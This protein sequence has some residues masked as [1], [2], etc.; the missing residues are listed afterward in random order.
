MPCSVRST[1]V[2]KNRRSPSLMSPPLIIAKLD[3]S[4]ESER[5]TQAFLVR[6][7]SGRWPM[8]RLFGMRRQEQKLYVAVEWVR[9]V[10]AE[11]YS[12]VELALDQLALCWRDYP[13]IAAARAALAALDGKERP[14]G[15]PAA[16]ALVEGSAH[17]GA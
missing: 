14:P 2:P 7:C 8:W 13:T 3:L 4:K 5:D 9:I 11:R 10:R 1:S 15:T 16:P 6:A 17:H 12:L